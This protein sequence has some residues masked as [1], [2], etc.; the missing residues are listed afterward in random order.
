MPST[1][2][3]GPTA[4]NR[5]G[6]SGSDVRTRDAGRR[7]AIGLRCDTE[8]PLTMSGSSGPR[9]AGRGGDDQAS[10]TNRRNRVQGKKCEDGR[11]IT[12][13][14][15]AGKVPPRRKGHDL[16]PRRD[17]SL[18]EGPDLFGGKE[19]RVWGSEFRKRRPGLRL[20]PFDRLRAGRFRAGPF[21]KLRAGPGR[22]PDR[23]GSMFPLFAITA[24]RPSSSRRPG[25]GRSRMRGAIR[26]AA[27]NC[28]SRAR[29]SPSRTLP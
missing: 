9:A 2:D 5:R 11:T 17:L 10:L 13:D 19:F 12:P 6:S 14:D 25:G 23:T 20:A 3:A 29:R 15:G 8:P 16:L 28:A 24:A 18:G 26:S 27:R 21:D 1:S 4:R 7:C 22:S